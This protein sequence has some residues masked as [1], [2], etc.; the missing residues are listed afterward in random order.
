MPN[1]LTITTI[2]L[3]RNEQGDNAVH[4]PRCERG[5]RK[6]LLYC[7]VKPVCTA[8]IFVIT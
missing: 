6:M 1:D 7:V 8:G 4:M 3:G 2:F 5:L